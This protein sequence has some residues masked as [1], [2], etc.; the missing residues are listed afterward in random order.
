[1]KLQLRTLM[2]FVV[3]AL[4]LA[5]VTA[6]AAP[7]PAEITVSA[8][9]STKTPDQNSNVY[10]FV[11]VNADKKTRAKVS[12]TFTWNFASGAKTCTAKTD[13]RGIAWCKLN[14]GMVPYGTPITIQAALT[15]AGQS[16]TTQIKFTPTRAGSATPTTTPA[17][18]PTKRPSPSL[19]PKTN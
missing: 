11:L 13:S 16:Y 9:M 1:M 14:I 19:P 15:I 10:A 17:P 5:P 12:V 8:W 7:R 2:A 4:G 3:V 18:I 6:Q